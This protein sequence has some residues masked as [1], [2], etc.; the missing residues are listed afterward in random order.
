LN[1]APGLNLVPSGEFGPQVDPRVEVAPPPGV[2]FASKGEVGPP[3]MKFA[4][5]GEVGP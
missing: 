2:T 5:G 4:P 1:L 3:G